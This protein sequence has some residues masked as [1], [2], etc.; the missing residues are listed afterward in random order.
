MSKLIHRG[1]AIYIYPNS[2]LT[3]CAATY[4]NLYVKQI[5]KSG[6]ALLLSL[7]AFILLLLLYDLPIAFAGA[8]LLI[9]LIFFKDNRKPESPTL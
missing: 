5:G 6:F 7:M 3:I 9:F 4:P 8:V 2:R 1:S